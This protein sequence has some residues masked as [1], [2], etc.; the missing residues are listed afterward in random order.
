[1]ALQDANQIAQILQNALKMRQS[2]LETAQQQAAEQQRIDIA[3][4]QQESEESYRKAEADRFNKNYELQQKQLDL[5]RQMQDLSR[6]SL[7]QK[8]TENYLQTGA[9]FPGDQII[10]NTSPTSGPLAGIG[11]PTVT[12]N[13]PGIAPFETV[14]PEVFTQQQVARQE[15]MNAPAEAKAAAIQKSQAEERLR[16]ISVQAANA[17]A[18]E[19]QRE[20]YE[21]QRQATDLKARQSMDAQN[22]ARALQ[23]SMISATGGM[24][25]MPGTS[26]DPTQ[27]QR[28]LSNGNVR[29]SLDSSGK[30]QIQPI[31]MPTIVQNRIDSGYNGKLTLDQLKKLYP[32]KGQFEYIT[33]LAAQRGVVF[34]TDAQMTQAADLNQVAKAG[35]ILRDMALLHANNSGYGL[36]NIWNPLSSSGKQFSQDEQELGKYLPAISRVL[37]NVRRFNQTEI[38]SYKNGLQPSKAP[39]STPTNGI[40]KYN[41]YITDLQNDYNVVFG[42]LPDGQ[43]ANLIKQYGGTSLPSLKNV[44][45]QPGMP[46]TTPPGMTPPLAPAPV[47]PL[48]ALGAG[49][50]Q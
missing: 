24:F 19:A 47:N 12:H 38:D 41:S 10:P 34:P 30:P 9:P 29:I 4:K 46:L 6:D 7:V 42:S 23:A 48:G 40:D 27:P 22:N 21:T 13:I 11:T 33:N 14:T 25:G 20:K 3:N 44:I 32:L 15:A 17:Q 2:K 1:M 43:R 28:P 37:A 50:Q 39:W 36:G 45:T 26:T 5:Q 35:P 18:L 31:D 49:A 16:E 8:A